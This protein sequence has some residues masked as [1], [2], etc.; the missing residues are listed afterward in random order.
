LGGEDYKG[1]PVVRV[2]IRER[3]WEV[4]LK[5][6]W[7]GGQRFAYEKIASGAAEG[8]IFFYRVLTEDTQLGNG[9]DHHPK[10]YSEIKCRL[11]AWL[12]RQQ[13]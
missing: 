4:R 2:L 5:G 9:S 1:Q 7:F 8:E 11:V 10:A 6:V 13:I 3:W 12:P